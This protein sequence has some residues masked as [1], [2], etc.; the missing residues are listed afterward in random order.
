MKWSSEGEQSESEELKT[1]KDSIVG[2]LTHSHT[3]RELQAQLVLF[4]FLVFFPWL[5]LCGPIIIRIN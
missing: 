4:V 5:L 1:A 3:Q 2:W